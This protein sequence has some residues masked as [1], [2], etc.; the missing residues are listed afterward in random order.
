MD[1]SAG[2]EDLIAF[3]SR[4]GARD[5]LF[6]RRR[7]PERTCGRSPTTR[8]RDRRPDLLARRQA[9][10]PS[11]P[12]G[13]AATRSG[14]WSGDG[15]GL[16]A[17]Y[18]G[19]GDLI[20]EAHWSPDGRAIAT[21]SGHDRED[22]H[23]STTPAAWRAPRP[24][25]HP[26]PKHVL[27]PAGMVARRKDRRRFRDP[28]AGPGQHV[29]RWLY[30]PGPGAVVRP[31]VH[32]DRQGGRIR[33]G[34][35]VGSRATSSTWTATCASPT[36]AHGRGPR[37]ARTAGHRRIPER[38]LRAARSQTCYVVRSTDNAD[39]W[40]MT[41]GRSEKGDSRGGIASSGPTRSSA[42][43]APAEWARCTAR[44][45]PRLGRDVAIKVLPASFPQDGGAARALRAGSAGA[46]GVLNHPNIT[47]VYD[48]GSA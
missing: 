37:R 39:I 47:A 32:D 27:R 24:S 31:V 11:T 5:D 4:G 1:V 15:S 22:P 6:P 44:K 21:N 41:A 2:R 40:Q 30:T 23:A 19:E 7:A 33:R 35:F 25:R 34:A 14:R 18:E 45:D 26:V 13:A 8:S 29:D 28:D 38:R 17:I 16:K 3:D 43:S 20:I 12:T 10:S 46:A 9:H 48:I 36:S 42:R